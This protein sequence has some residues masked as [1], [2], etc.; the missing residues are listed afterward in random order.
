MGKRMSLL[1]ASAMTVIGLAAGVAP[2]HAAPGAE[3]YSGVAYSSVNFLGKFTILPTSSTSCAPLHHRHTSARNDSWYFTI[4]LYNDLNCSDVV[5]VLRP[6]DSDSGYLE[7]VESGMLSTL[8]YSG[9]YY[10]T[11]SL[12]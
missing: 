10:Y 9:A 12:F 4:R 11:V 7:P 3:P 8:G 5:A 1:L 2:A 6:G